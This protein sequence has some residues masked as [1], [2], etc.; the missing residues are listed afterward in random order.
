MVQHAVYIVSFPYVFRH[1]FSIPSDRAQ[2]TPRSKLRGN[3]F[4][5]S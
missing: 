5:Y 2:G 1:A 3:L 4:D